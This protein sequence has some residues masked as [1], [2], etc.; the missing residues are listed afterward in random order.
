MPLSLELIAGVNTI[1]SGVQAG[2]AYMIFAAGYSPSS[3]PNLGYRQELT[4][5]PNCRP[6][7]VRSRSFISSN[8]LPLDGRIDLRLIYV[9]TRHN[10][11]FIRV[12]HLIDV[13]RARKY[14]SFW[15]VF[16]ITSRSRTSLFSEQGRMHIPIYTFT[17][18][19]GWYLSPRL[20]IIGEGLYLR[21]EPS[22]R[23]C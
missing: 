10:I 21:S 11:Y 4:T 16:I 22:Q 12:Y 3:E 9:I 8:N 17:S 6:N 2:L 13:R 19:Y 20:S 7:Y 23:L 14:F 15:L 18:L 5:E 1:R